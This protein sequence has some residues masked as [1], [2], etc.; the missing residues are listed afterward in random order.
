[1]VTLAHGF[2]DKP[3]CFWQNR[4][5]PTNAGHPCFWQGLRAAL[6]TSLNTV[7]RYKTHHRDTVCSHR[8]TTGSRTRNTQQI[9]SVDTSLS[10]I[11][12]SRT[13][14]GQIV[15]GPCQLLAAFRSR[16]SLCISAIRSRHLRSVIKKPCSSCHFLSSVI[17]ASL[18]L[19]AWRKSFKV[20][21]GF[22]PMKEA[23][24]VYVLPSLPHVI[25][26]PSFACIMFPQA[27][28]RIAAK[29]CSLTE[30]VNHF[31][32]IFSRIDFVR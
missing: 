12:S 1:V 24:A 32:S 4:S 7:Q 3:A 21:R 30:W 29:C 2:L 8:H 14:G 9:G 13:S 26:F 16:S 18:C 5:L 17:G 11:Q 28:Q 10:D 23:G 19:L 31:P 20:T 22:R 25:V 27:S 15:L 6:P